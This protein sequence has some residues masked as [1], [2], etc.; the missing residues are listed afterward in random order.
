VFTHCR[1][2]FF[3][4]ASPA[5]SMRT[6]AAPDSRTFMPDPPVTDVKTT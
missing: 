6:S 4:V 1:P 5:A 2:F 3:S